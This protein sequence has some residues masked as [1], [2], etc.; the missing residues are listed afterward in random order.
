L[1]LSSISDFRKKHLS[2]SEA[3]DTYIAQ[4]GE[5]ALSVNEPFKISETIDPVIV[6]LGRTTT[7]FYRDSKR[8]LTGSL[9]TLT[10]EKGNVYILGRREPPDSKLIAWSSKEEI[11]IDQYDTRVRIIPSRV[12]VAFVALD[13]GEVL[14]TDLG[15][16]SGSIL[17]GE[18]AKPDP[19]IT[20]Y[21]SPSVGI[22]RVTIPSK[23]ARATAK[24]N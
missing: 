2:F 6:I 22:H 23:Y 15:S 20:L 18:S 7:L 9:A 17:A 3:Y 14:F 16:S 4:Y 13:S 1:V 12:H 24:A 5:S 21:A 10:I 11:E 8:T 19:F